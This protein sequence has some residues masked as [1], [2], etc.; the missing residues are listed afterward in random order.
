MTN[1]KHSPG[2]WHRDDLLALNGR[3]VIARTTGR[4]P[5]SANTDDW[6]GYDGE[7]EANAYVIAAAPELLE[8]LEA[9][10]DWI[11]AQL[12]EPRLEIQ[13]KVQAA[14]AKA[15]GRAA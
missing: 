2:P 9:A 8:A 7:D 10:S 14:I 13:A 12:G 11:D 4:I 1:I 3:P 15:T 6:L 5:I